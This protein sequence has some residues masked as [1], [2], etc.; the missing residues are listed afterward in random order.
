MDNCRYEGCN[1]EVFEDGYCILHINLPADEKSEEFKRINALKGEK[2]QEKIDNKD[3]NFEGAKLSLFSIVNDNRIG[4]LNLS[5]AHITKFIEVFDSNIGSIRLDEAKVEGYVIFQD[6]KIGSD[7]SLVD[8]NIKSITI[9]QSKKPVEIFGDIRLKNS[10]INNI[11]FNGIKAR[12]YVFLNG[13]II[14]GDVLFYDVDINIDLDFSNTEIG[15]KAVFLNVK[16]NGDF[17]FNNAKISNDIYVDVTSRG[18]YFNHTLFKMPETQEK[19][20]RIIR[21]FWEALGDKEEADYY[22]YHEMEAK[23][24]Q[25]PFYIRKPEWIFQK[26]FAYGVYP[27]RL[28]VT[29]SFIFIGFSLIYWY[30]TGIYINNSFNAA[31]LI[32]SI[33]FSFLTLIIPAYGIVSQSAVNYG[34]WIIIEAIF[35]AFMWPLFIAV[36]ARKYMR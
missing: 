14:K 20:C 18:M 13:N 27:L 36:F 33:R 21:N 9:N 5:K 16:M 7:I 22:F 25:K 31:N 19:T 15:D 29:F 34:I 17:K 24:K 28:F 2:V 4:K 6:S 1:E 23:R 10:I 30:K 8:A 35:G 12:R 11:M 3:F 26:S 32:N